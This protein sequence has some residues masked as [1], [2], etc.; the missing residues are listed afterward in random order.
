MDAFVGR[1]DEVAEL[2]AL[3]ASA[4]LVTLI[5]PGGV[6]KTR[7]ALELAARVGVN[8]P[9][10]V[11]LV[12]LAGVSDGRLLAHRV[13]ESLGIHL[14]RPAEARRET[15][16]LQLGEGRGEPVEP[17]LVD[18][19]RGGRVL[20]VLDNCEH[21][22]DDSARLAVTLLRACP[23]L[24]VLTTSRQP[25]D[26]PGEHLYP[27]HGLSLAPAQ[28]PR[29]RGELLRSDAVRLF[30]ERAR[31][32][33]PAFELTKENGDEIAELCA[34]LDGNP[35]AIELAARQ[36]RQRPIGHILDRLDDRLRLLSQG[37]R[38]AEERHRDL[39]AAIGWSYEL[40]DPDEQ[41]LFRRLGVLTGWFTVNDVL[42]ACGD[43]GHT[44]D[45]LLD[46]L[47]RLEAGSLVEMESDRSGVRFRLTESIRLYAQERLAGAGEDDD[48]YERL[49]AW[50]LELAA[51]VAGDERL[52]RSADDLAPLAAEF[53]TLRNA[54]DWATRRGDDRRA[55]LATAFAHC[56]VRRNRPDDAR[57]LL[58]AAL[59]GVD[60]AYPGRVPALA[61]A[62]L[63]AARDGHGE[64]ATE[65]AEEGLAL[66]RATGGP[67]A[68][69]RALL[70]LQ[71]V[72]SC[73]GDP[74]AAETA[75]RECLALFDGPDAGASANL[76]TCL[77]EHARLALRT[78]DL[79]H[80]GTLLD[81]CRSIHRDLH[82]DEAGPVP[83]E[84]V[85]TAAT[86]ALLRGDTAAAGL[87]WKEALAAHR[88]HG[89]AP[90]PPL[91]LEM[92][93]GLA[94]V[95]ARGGDQ[96][97]AVR[98]AAAAG[99]LH[100]GPLV[101]C[102]TIPADVLTEAVGSARAALSPAAAATAGRNGERLDVPALIA[103][104]LD[105]T[106]TEPA[107]LAAEPVLTDRERQVALLIAEGLPNRQIARRLHVSERTV[108]THLERIRSKLGLPSRTHI[109]R[110]VMEEAES[111]IES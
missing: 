79:D 22:V 58:D 17:L 3:L 48:A 108:H 57:R 68:L 20:L 98:L 29:T 30:V 52:P 2:K 101:R 40:L 5:G 100:D 71:A 39:R 16:G 18:L 7:L 28:V 11:W 49:V 77:H 54:V 73:T 80:A 90:L 81:R 109:V 19:L 93:A 102:G 13:A 59:A 9:D 104:A 15:H 74:D 72:R 25:L 69:A 43:D 67:V 34:R 47:G 32:V 10:G 83:V 64:R 4:R 96:L 78:G 6:G 61:Y 88:T 21:L 53:D 106:W 31:A 89:D 84:W 105:G 55:L 1:E 37:V 87:R 82:S 70:A 35:L 92:I 38:T 94:V 24:T 36:A 8:H 75:M 65:L 107:G 12:E 66:A 45:E 56:L 86:Y 26:A 46:Q 63:L 103:Y 60:P 110:W 99:V 41:R 51:P 85:H 76:A 91:A 44:A 95:A 33:S 50:L 111:T 14:G 42:E 27:V 97:R 23:G 62:A